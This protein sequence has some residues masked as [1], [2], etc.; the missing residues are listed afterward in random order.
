MKLTT[1]FRQTHDVVY[2][3]SQSIDLN[4]E[5]EWLFEDKIFATNHLTNTTTVQ[6]P[7]FENDQ[8]TKGEN[9]TG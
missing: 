6:A 8:K 7:Q 1:I 5:R 3:N 9:L 4:E 2:F